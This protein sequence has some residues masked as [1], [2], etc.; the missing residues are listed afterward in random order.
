[1]E[2]K[3][4][5]RD[6]SIFHHK[7]GIV[8]DTVGNRVAFVGSLNETRSGWRQNWESVWTWKRA[9]KPTNTWR[10][11]A[12]W[13]AG[14]GI[15][16]CSPPRRC[17]STKWNCGRCWNCWRPTAGTLPNTAAFIRTCR[18]RRM[19]R[20]PTRRNGNTAALCGAKRIPPMPAMSCRTATTMISSPSG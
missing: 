15:C 8:D 18:M 19:L 20:R 3:V 5:I 2:V 13:R 7:R 10:C 16:C 4:A 17:S 12:N 9:A 1:M 11:C 6:G 14:R